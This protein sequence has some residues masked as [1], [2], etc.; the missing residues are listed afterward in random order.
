MGI[1][2]PIGGGNYT[3]VYF[4]SNGLVTLGGASTSYT[5]VAMPTTGVPAV[6]LAA[7]WDD[8]RSD[9]GGISITYGLSGSAPNRR[10]V[11]SYNSV[12]VT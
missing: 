11:I 8:L 10:F 5:N 3:Q 2:V 9:T 1:T 7:F 4:N 12:T 6:S